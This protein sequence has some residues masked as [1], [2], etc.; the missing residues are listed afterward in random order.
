MKIALFFLGCIVVAG[1]YGAFSATKKI[2][3]VQ[4]LPAILGIVAV[5]LSAY[6]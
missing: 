4:S 1:I 5:L 2:F 6:L 3:F